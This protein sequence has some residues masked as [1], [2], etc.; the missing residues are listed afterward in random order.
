MASSSDD[1]DDDEE[2]DDDAMDADGAGGQQAPQAVPLESTGPKGPV[3]DEDGFTMVQGK[4]RRGK[5]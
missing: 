3:V 5:R 4:G 2:G 1:E